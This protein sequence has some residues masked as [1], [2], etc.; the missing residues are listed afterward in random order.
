MQSIAQVTTVSASRY[1]QQ[2]CRH[3]G[4]RFPVSFD[5][6]QG[7]VAFDGT[8]CLFQA[9]AEQLIITLETTGEDTLERMEGVVADHLRRFAFREDLVVH[10]SRSTA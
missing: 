2:L 4:H 5:E 3:W 6:S 7:S 8:T 9:A 1:L 10:W